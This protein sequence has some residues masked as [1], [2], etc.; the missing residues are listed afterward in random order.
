MI[1]VI[2]S[3]SSS[4]VVLFLANVVDII[5][6]AATH[7]VKTAGRV[8]SYESKNK[9]VNDG[10]SISTEKVYRSRVLFSYNGQE[11]L[12]EVDIEKEPQIGQTVQLRADPKDLSDAS[13]PQGVI[14]P[15]IRTVAET[16]SLV[17]IVYV[18]FG[19][20]AGRITNF[21]ADAD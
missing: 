20:E 4:I 18:I 2:I 14:K 9:L 12:S 5:F 19:W 17:V 6:E 15:I 11:Y 3:S 7:S 16:A 8:V 1:F 21:N 10:G 13:L